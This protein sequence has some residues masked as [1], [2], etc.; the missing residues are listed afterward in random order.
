M[1]EQFWPIL[2]CKTIISTLNNQNIDTFWSGPIILTPKQQNLDKYWPEK[3]KYWQFFTWKAKIWT[4]LTLKKAKNWQK[5]VLV[6]ID[7]T[8]G[9]W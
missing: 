4:N 5:M 1:I 3:L 2:I 6:M 9:C 7:G 8:D